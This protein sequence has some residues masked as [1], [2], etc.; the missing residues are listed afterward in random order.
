MKQYNGPSQANEELSMQIM[1]KFAEL[2]GNFI[3]TANMY[4]VGTSEEIVG[5]WLSK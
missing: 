4:N 3:D 2:G 1:D 5:K